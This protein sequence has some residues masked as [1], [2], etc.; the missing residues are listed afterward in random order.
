[1]AIHSLI[2][3]SQKKKHSFIGHFEYKGKTLATGLESV[4]QRN[5][6]R[7]MC[8]ELHCFTN[9][10]WFQNITQL[11]SFLVQPVKLQIASI[12]IHWY[13]W[14]GIWNNLTFLLIDRKVISLPNCF[15]TSNFI[16][17]NICIYLEQSFLRLLGK[18]HSNRNDE[19]GSENEKAFNLLLFPLNTIAD[20]EHCFDSSVST[21]SNR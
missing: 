20:Y 16:T 3:L 2:G 21:K 4:L 9:L 19:I 15:F 18:N 7:Y 5:C 8:P 10:C 1:M 17:T 6:G 13:G 11:F 12:V 14:Q